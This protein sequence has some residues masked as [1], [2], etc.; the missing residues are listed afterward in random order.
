MKVAFISRSTL[1]TVKGGDTFQI[2][3]TARHLTSLGVEVDI[4]LTHQPIDYKKYDL[5]HFFNIIRP[6]DI[7]YH[8]DRS[9]TPFVVSP[10]LVDY[11]EYDRLYRK[12]FSGSLFRYLP[13]D[14]IE[15]LKAIARWVKGN[16]SL[17]S[18]SYL[19][20]GHASSIK[21][22]LR[23]TAMVLPNSAMEYEQ[24]AT[25]DLSMPP[26]QLIP[27]GIDPALFTYNCSIPKDPNLVLCV[28]RI[29]GRKNQLHLI[30]ALNNTH[31]Q[32]AIIGAPAP[33][34]PGYYAACRKTAASNISFIDPLTQEDLVPWYQKAA[35]HIL[36]SW[37][38]TCGLS[39]LEAAV[40]GCNVVIT[41][42]GFTRPYFGNDAVY[43]DPGSPASILEAVEKAAHQKNDGQL[44][45]KILNEFTWQQAAYQT[46]AAYK[47][48]LSKQ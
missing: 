37:F 40:M 9:N 45:R 15:Y 10:I 46:A 36:P 1:F 2:I 42:K 14:T 32:V 35:V 26:C 13:A 43:C 34:Q 20:K 5:L 31:Y 48:V 17:M 44:Q 21:K 47:Q 27:N 28:A 16:D 30:K 6:A 8:I 29:E 11:S 18:T 25:L 19:W 4:A 41:D 22:I 39:S 23:H 3:N 12:G 7:I 38:E 33:N 24:L